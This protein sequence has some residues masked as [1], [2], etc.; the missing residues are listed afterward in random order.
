MATLF[1]PVN[2]TATVVN[3]KTINLTWTLRT[4]FDD[5]I[6]IQRKTLGGAYADI[7]DTY[8]SDTAVS[9]SNC[10]DGTLYYFKVRGRNDD[11]D[12][13]YTYS[14]YSNEASATTILPAPTSLAGVANSATQVTLTWKDNSTNETGFE[15]YRSTAGATYALISTTAASAQ[16]YV[17]TGLSVSVPYAYKIRAINDAAT[18]VYSTYSN[19]V[20]LTTDSGAVTLSNTGH[21]DILIIDTVSATIDN[22]EIVI[23][24][25]GEVVTS[26]VLTRKFEI[27]A[28][29][30]ATNKLDATHSDNGYPI[31]SYIRTKDLDFT[32]QHPDL[33]GIN[34][35]VKKFRLLYEDVDA[36]A[37]VTVYISNDGGV[38]WSSCAAVL[39]DGGGA[40]KYADFHF[41]DAEYCTG[42]NFTFKVES[43]STTKSF[44][45][46]A[47]EVEFMVRGESF[48]V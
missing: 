33:A 43:L 26:D 37:P 10:G 47:F 27:I 21:Q 46:L 8:G 31:A 16:T 19:A 14:E 11:G 7:G 9:I 6:Q 42:L 35:T 48:N 45:W 13:T 38:N 22:P 3:D 34:K 29:D 12:G 2:L 28:T 24:P 17:D 25:T 36:S 15:V 20:S 41:M 39:G 5:V 18:H 1:S 44:L 23:P 32:D 40:V 30:A 4:V